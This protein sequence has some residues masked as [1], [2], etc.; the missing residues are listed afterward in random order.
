MAGYNVILPGGTSINRIYFLLLA[1]ACWAIFSSL[2]QLKLAGNPNGCVAKN[3]CGKSTLDKTNWW[4]TMVVGSVS[5]LIV[6]WP[7]IKRFISALLDVL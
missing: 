2:E 7:I 1:A 3:T 5:T 4:G 6:I